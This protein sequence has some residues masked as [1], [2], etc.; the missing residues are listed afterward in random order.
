MTTTSRFVAT[1]AVSALVLFGLPSYAAG[2]LASAD[3]S[4]LKDIAQADISEVE[5]GKLDVDRSGNAEAKN[6]PR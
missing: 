6:L 2:K 4:L 5:S 3:E 1:A